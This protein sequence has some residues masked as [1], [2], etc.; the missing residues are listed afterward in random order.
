LLRGTSGGT[1]AVVEL[2]DAAG[3]WELS[4]ADELEA[5]V[6]LEEGAV[7]LCDPPP[8]A[9][10]PGASDAARIVIASRTFMARA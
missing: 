4:D 2:A 6:A 7:V 5:G 3:A 8:Q 1:L 9:A 10:S